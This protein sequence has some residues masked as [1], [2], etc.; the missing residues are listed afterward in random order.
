MLSTICLLLVKG[1][2]ML[3]G[4]WVEIPELVL[5][6]SAI[7]SIMFADVIWH[8]ISLN[9]IRRCVLQRGALIGISVIVATF[10]AGEWSFVVFEHVLFGVAISLDMQGFIEFKESVKPNP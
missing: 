3:I 1:V 5:T 6:I 8:G 7:A 2:R 4:S 9:T 10:F